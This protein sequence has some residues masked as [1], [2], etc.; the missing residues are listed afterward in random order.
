MEKKFY[1]VPVFEEIHSVHERR[2]IGQIIVE[3]KLLGVKEVVSGIEMDV[4]SSELP[5]FLFAEADTER[6]GHYIYVN[7]YSLKPENIATREEV[8]TYV[9]EYEQNPFRKIADDMLTKKQQAKAMKKI[10]SSKKNN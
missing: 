4:V 5:L 3:K 1:K 9:D 6:L 7:R 2:Q 10:R 8:A